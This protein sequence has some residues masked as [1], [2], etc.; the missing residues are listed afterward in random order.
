MY[1]LHGFFPD[2]QNGRCAV[3]SLYHDQLKI[4]QRMRACS[5]G[6]TSSV[7]GEN[8]FETTIGSATGNAFV[9]ML[10]KMHLYS[11]CVQFF[12]HLPQES[13]RMPPKQPNMDSSKSHYCM[14]TG[15]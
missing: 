15:T 9:G 6:K 7:A 13:S 4:Y 11:I 2:L 1:G 3:P 5:G 10:F 8:S 14:S 12:I